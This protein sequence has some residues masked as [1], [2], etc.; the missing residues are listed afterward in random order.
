MHPVSGVIPLTTISGVA[1]VAIT[2]IAARG[3]QRRSDHRIGVL[4]EIISE[5]EDRHGTK[6]SS[7][8]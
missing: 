2:E 3:L 1:R 4:V 8:Q 5:N 7:G 6:G